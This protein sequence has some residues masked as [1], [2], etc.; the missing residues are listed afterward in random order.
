MKLELFGK[1]IRSGGE[2]YQSML[3]SMSRRDIVLV[4]RPEYFEWKA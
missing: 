4:Y 1:F 2:N 3:L